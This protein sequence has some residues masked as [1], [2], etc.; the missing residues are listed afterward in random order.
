MQNTEDEDF[1]LTILD[2]AGQET[3][4][5]LVIEK[6]LKLISEK[7]MIGNSKGK[8]VISEFLDLLIKKEDPFLVALATLGNE[9]TINALGVL[10]FVAFQL[11]YNFGSKD[12]TFADPVSESA[13]EMVEVTLPTSATSEN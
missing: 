8:F 6:I 10:L 7:D 9:K 13:E 12:L 3:N 5:E 4:L 2:K 11:G 1:K